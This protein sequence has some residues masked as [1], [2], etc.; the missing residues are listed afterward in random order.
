MRLTVTH[1]RLSKTAVSGRREVDEKFRG[2]KALIDHSFQEHHSRP[3]TKAGPPAGLFTTHHIHL[4]QQ[5][6]RRPAWA[7]SV[8]SGPYNWF[9]ALSD[10]YSTGHTFRRWRSAILCNDET[11]ELPP[12]PPYF[13]YYP[14][15]PPMIG[16][17]DV[18]E[19]ARNLYLEPLVD[20]STMAIDGTW[21]DLPQEVVD[22][23]MFMLGDNLESLKA[24]S[25]TCKAMFV[26]ARRLIHR[27]IFLTWEQN[28]DVLTLRERQRY[29]R[30]E[31]RGLT[32]KMISTTTARGLLPHGRHLF[33][34]F[35][36]DFTPANL[37]PFNDHFQRY[38]R[39]QDLTIFWFHPGDFLEQFDTFFANFVPTLRSL[40]L[41]TPKG[42]TRDILDFVCRFPH[43]D[44][45]TIGTVHE[46]SP[47]LTTW[48]TAPLPVVKKVPSFRGRLKLYGIYGRHHNLLQQLISLPGKRRFRFIHFWGYPAEMGQ[49]I[50]DACGDTI[51]TLSATWWKSCEY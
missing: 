20:L 28:W 42:N 51:E 15:P 46:Y 47:N 23:I 22:H 39:I 31:R 10:T 24:C 48:E 37:Q 21:K 18:D 49:H 12:N 26:A 13:P 17:A 25:L 4:I 14:P 30:G 29:V 16:S 1:Q 44:N 6:E 32:I 7:T 38:E 2:A 34:D 27:K 41:K 33:I 3:Q 50:V 8:S 5:S 19:H 45:L 40:H 11:V 9:Q 36:E 43:L 35:R